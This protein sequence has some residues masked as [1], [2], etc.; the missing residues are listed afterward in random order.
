MILSTATACCC[1]IKNV[2]YEIFTGLNKQLISEFMSRQDDNT[3]GS[4]MKSSTVAMTIQFVFLILTSG[5]RVSESH[6]WKHQ[7]KNVNTYD[8]CKRCTTSTCSILF[9]TFANRDHGELII[10]E[11]VFFFFTFS[12][13]LFKP[14]FVS[15]FFFII[16]AGA[17]T[18]KLLIS[19]RPLQDIRRTY[20]ILL[21]TPGRF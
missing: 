2:I 9:S 7:D 10:K 6:R 18:N 16:P 8:L 20:I 4:M 5:S 12:A 11:D 13:K 19:E 1:I 14:R 21:G 3:K 15:F 17:H